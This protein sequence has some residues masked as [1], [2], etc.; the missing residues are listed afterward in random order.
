M[1]RGDLSSVA[2]QLTRVDAM[3]EADKRLK[4][5]CPD[6]INLEIIAIAG[7]R[8]FWEIEA[9]PPVES[10]SCLDILLKR[11]LIIEMP[12]KDLALVRDRGS[13]TYY[14]LTEKGYELYDRILAD[15]QLR[16]NL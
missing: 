3:R 2:G 15:F 7:R 11:G 13:M 12:F 14:S 16:V 5:K 6:A 1:V 10:G 9:E 8:G 4:G